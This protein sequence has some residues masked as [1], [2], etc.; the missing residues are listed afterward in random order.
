MWHKETYG[1]IVVEEHEITEK[2]QRTITETLAGD[3][4]DK[5]MEREDTFLR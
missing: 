3:I 4:I 2:L 5:T 1:D